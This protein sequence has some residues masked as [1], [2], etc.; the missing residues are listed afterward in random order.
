MGQI[1]TLAIAQETG[2]HL[3]IDGGLGTDDRVLINTT[4]IADLAGFSFTNVARPRCAAGS[5]EVS[6]FAKD[7]TSV[8]GMRSQPLPCSPNAS[9]CRSNRT[10][11]PN[12]RHRTA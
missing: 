8:K 2:A 1:N 11:L 12:S 6:F 5:G 7:A 10:C 3:T 4:E 9:T